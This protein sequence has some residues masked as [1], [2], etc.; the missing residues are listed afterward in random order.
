MYAFFRQVFEIS[1]IARTGANAHKPKEKLNINPNNAIK[2]EKKSHN[3]SQNPNSLNFNGWN[4]D[5]PE[6][7][8]KGGSEILKIITF[9]KRIA[10]RKASQRGARFKKSA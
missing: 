9:L 2:V 5:E 10:H 7:I 4:I 1:S 3:S 6:K 8:E